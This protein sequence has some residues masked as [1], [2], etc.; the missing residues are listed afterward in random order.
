MFTFY[1]GEGNV[2]E[3]LRSQVAITSG[4][5]QGSAPITISKLLFQC[6]GCLNEIELS[7]NPVGL[8]TTSSSVLSDCILEEM[9]TTSSKPRWSGTVD[10]MIHPG[11]TKAYGFSGVLSRGWRR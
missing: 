10:L 4:A 7:H 11:Q 8:S 9:S 2:G 6:K 3:P 5:R 1:E